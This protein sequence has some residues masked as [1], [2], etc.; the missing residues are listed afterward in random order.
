MSDRS[1]IEW[2]D[3][4]WNPVTGCTKVSAGCANCYAETFAERWRGIEGHYFERGFDLV[5][6]PEKLYDPL[7]W[8][9]RRRVF[10]NSM[11]DLFHERVSDEYIEQVFAVMAIT[12]HTYQVLTKRADRALEFTSRGDLGHAIY[13]W[14]SYWLDEGDRGFL[15]HHWDRVHDLSGRSTTGSKFDFT[16]WKLPLPNVWLGVSVEDQ[17]TA[18]ERIPVLLDCPAS[19]RFVSAEP[20]LG[21]VDL[22]RLPYGVIEFADGSAKPC[23]IN[24]LECVDRHLN[25]VIAGGESGPKSREYK[26]EWA[27]Y[28]RRQCAV[29]GVPFFHK[30]VG[31]NPTVNG[32][33]LK[34]KNR[35][36]ADPS[37]WPAGLDVRQMPKVEAA[38]T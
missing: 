28:L 19:V 12:K 16:A 9:T 27:E 18:D 4:T 37:E 22:T 10:V 25:W 21:P 34:L 31:R 23:T 38:A 26:T 1:K 13:R 36:G 30:Q 6:R 3:A 24:G 35:K 8:K 11:S 33:G 2:C 14:V 17:A 7:S 32:V 15:G 20:L 29:A 5:L